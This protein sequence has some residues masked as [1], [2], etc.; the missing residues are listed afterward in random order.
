MYIIDKEKAILSTEQKPTQQLQLHSPWI[1]TPPD[2]AVIAY[3]GTRLV[4]GISKLI[5]RMGHNW[6]RRVSLPVGSS[7]LQYGHV[8][9]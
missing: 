5:V 7:P 8:S 2:C 1:V 3:E 4:K 9:I 6:Q